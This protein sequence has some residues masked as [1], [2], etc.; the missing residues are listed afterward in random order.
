MDKHCMRLF[1]QLRRTGCPGLPAGISGCTVLRH[2]CIAYAPGM[3]IEFF[4]QL[5]RGAAWHCGPSSLL[6]RILLITC[7]FVSQG[8]TKQRASHVCDL[9]QEQQIRA[10]Q[11]MKALSARM[12]ANMGAKGAG[13]APPSRGVRILPRDMEQGLKEFASGVEQLVDKLVRCL[14]LHHHAYCKFAPVLGPNNGGPATQLWQRGGGVSVWQLC[15][16]P[17]AGRAAISSHIGLSL[18]E[19]AN[20][21]TGSGERGAGAEDGAACGECICGV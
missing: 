5:F 6:L 2:G 21:A 20:P 9:V 18:A 13:G 8:L 19:D 16:P 12:R 3:I 10:R 17:R 1:C 7:N 15:W 11:G 14:A 4:N